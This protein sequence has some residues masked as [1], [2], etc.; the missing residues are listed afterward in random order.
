MSLK[1]MI[2]LGIRP[3][4]INLYPLVKEISRRKGNC[5]I[6]HT[7]QHYS[8][9]FDKL[10]FEQ[11]KFPKPDYHLKVG[12]GTQAQ[13]MAALV[14][15]FE[16]VLLK[17]KPD[18]VFSFSDA[19]PALSG[20]V[21]SKMGIKVAHLEAGMRSY[22]WRMPE[23]KNRRLMDSISDYLFT[24][25]S[26]T[27]RNLLEEGIP[28]HRIFQIG[29]PIWDVLH[30]FRRQID[31]NNIM[32]KLGVERDG[33]F[34]VTAHR[35]ENV[36]V[37]TP[38][39]NILGTLETIYKKY[40]KRVIFPIHPRSRAS[41]KSFGL[42]VPEGTTLMDPLGFLEFSK[43]E[44]NAFCCVTDSGTVQE[45]A[46]IFKV[47]CVT[48]RISTERAETVEIGSNIVAGLNKKH[49][50]ESVDIMVNKKRN[51]KHPYGTPDSAKKTID[52]LEKRKKEIIS[53]KVWWDHPQVRK[54]YSVS[55]Y[56]NKWKNSLLPDCTF[57]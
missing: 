54:S 27:R 3:D 34:L 18:L 14:E 25:T 7:G 5:T 17:E 24:P 29:K 28:S 55:S 42:K 52:V 22:D 6:V 8:Y 21:A 12:S 48:M 36:G 50:L 2:V 23:E 47:P 51:W 9:F 39:K 44:K 11:L 1:Y 46:C 20:I 38:L 45:D 13:Q 31:E 19:N 16:K 49:I 41:I 4:I 53:P 32:E 43:L 40:G 30:L 26:G 57:D 15:R 35:P 56:V 37:K 33:Y 10:F